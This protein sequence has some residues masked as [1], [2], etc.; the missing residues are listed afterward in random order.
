MAMARCVTSMRDGT[1]WIAGQGRLTSW[2]QAGR[3][4]TAG[5]VGIVC[6]PVGLLLTSCATSA[7]PPT[8]VA[9]APHLGH[10]VTSD[11]LAGLGAQ[12]YPDGHG[13]PAGSGL[14]VDGAVLYG[15]YCASCHGREGQGATAPELIGGDGPL[16]AAEADKTLKTYW[17]YATTL[18]DT[19]A[20]GMP[21]ANPAAL[22][23]D[24]RYALCA[25]LL[26]RN[27][28]WPADRPLDGASLSAVQM[29]NRHGFIDLSARGN[30][31]P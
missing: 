10:P 9:L 18:F 29:P 17:P 3:R 12:I 4:L 25:F 14:A 7:P 22:S 21:P 19:L 20:R 16:S 8:A 15:Q 1:G 11:T 13:L 6:L 26:A 24:Q 5:L 23:D 27:G 30:P 31:Q 2:R 28:L